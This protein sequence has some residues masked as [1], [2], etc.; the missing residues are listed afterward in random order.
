[1]LRQDDVDLE[2]ILVDDH[3]DQP[4][5][6]E[7]KE[8]IETNGVRYI[9]HAE[10][11]GL[12]KARNTAIETAEGKYFSF[13]DDDDRWPQGFARR[14]VSTAESSPE[15]V[16]VVLSFSPDKS[17]RCASFFAGYPTLQEVMKR[18]VTPPVGA[19]LY[20]THLVKSVG[21]YDSRVSSGVDHDL[22][23]S[24]A[25]VN[26]RVA[27]CWGEPVIVGAAPH[28]TRMTTAEKHRRE[29]IARSL[30][31]WRPRLVEV[32][33]EDFFHHFHS[34]YRQSLD[35]RFFIESYRRGCYA[36]MVRKALSLYMLRILISRVLKHLRH[37][38]NLFPQYHGNFHKG[39]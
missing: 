38:C 23:I 1:V 18:G 13:C 27:A 17:R 9:R 33:G 19:Q 39:V 26:P 2:V 4:V 7:V 11:S 21:G 35:I 6:D 10:N 14:L 24:L 5:P 32:F 12:A 16:R 31:L 28:R 36:R 29:G 37:E 22:W 30:A 34:S 25:E 8:I 3:S 15:D 20:R